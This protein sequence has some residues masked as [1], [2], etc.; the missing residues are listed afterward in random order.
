M[1]EWIAEYIQLKEG[2]FVEEYSIDYE[3]KQVIFHIEE[4]QE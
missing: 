3:N 4:V 1:A 2:W